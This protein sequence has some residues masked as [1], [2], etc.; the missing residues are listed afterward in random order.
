MAEEP[1]LDWYDVC[2][3][4]I[5][6]KGWNDTVG[7]FDRLPARAQRV[8]RDVIWDLSRKPTGVT[9]R[10]SAATTAIHARWRLE[11]P[12]ATAAKFCLTGVAGLD[13]YGDDGTGTMR[14]VGATQQFNS[15]DARDVLLSGM[16]GVQRDYTLYLPLRAAVER[17]EIGVPEGAQVSPV[18]AR[19]GKPIVFYG[20]SIVHGAGA[21]RAGMTH[22]AILGRR[23]NR[24]ILNLGFSG[25]AI[26]E[27]E[28]AELLAELD[29]LFYVVDPLPNMNGAA[30]AERG[31]HFI[32]VLRNARPQTPIVMVE[33]RTYTNAWIRPDAQER[34]RYS[35][36]EFRNVYNRLLASGAS[37]LLYVRGEHLFGDDNDASNDS[38]HPSDLGFVRMA[39]ALEPVLRPLV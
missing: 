37:G 21:S 4:G 2:E 8:V 3:F 19:A 14:W 5:E 11:D 32:R 7:P 35:R 27:P 12:P 16:D 25:N 33:D 30:V 23:L 10:F 9:A 28:V 1:R 17:V 24:P 26:M 22:P 39:D 29:P 18:P 36:T 20:T 6:G 13:L 31:E 15:Q 38:S 34:H